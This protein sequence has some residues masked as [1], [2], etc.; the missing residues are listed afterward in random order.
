MYDDRTVVHP[1]QKNGLVTENQNHTI[2]L[3][4]WQG[5]A[6][7]GLKSRKSTSENLQKVARF[8]Q[9]ANTAPCLL[10]VWLIS[11]AHANLCWFSK[12]CVVDLLQVDLFD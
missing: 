7:F 12:H 3:L 1:S 9:Q 8:S 5:C 10:I 6:Q 2:S 4:S 11:T